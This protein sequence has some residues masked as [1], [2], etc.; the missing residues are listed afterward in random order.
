MRIKCY[1]SCRRNKPPIP[2]DS[3]WVREQIIIL[4][5]VVREGE[6]C[7]KFLPAPNKEKQHNNNQ[8][9]LYGLCAA[10]TGDHREGAPIRKAISYASSGP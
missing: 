5:E 7:L 8:I 4:L 1:I 6:A 10:K 9:L 3:L 2:D